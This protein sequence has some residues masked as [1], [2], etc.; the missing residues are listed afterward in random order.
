MKYSREIKW[1]NQKETVKKT[2]L[3]FKSSDMKAEDFMKLFS[4]SK[5]IRPDLGMFWSDVQDI[6]EEID[7]CD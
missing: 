2:I 7:R 3:E 4:I 1:E 5:Y 6:I